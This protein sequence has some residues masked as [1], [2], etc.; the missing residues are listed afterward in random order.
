MIR[1]EKLLN[2]SLKLKLE[3]LN[4]ESKLEKYGKLHEC[5]KQESK[6]C[7]KADYRAIEQM[8]KIG[9]NEGE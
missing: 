6:Y 1:R 8:S 9:G 4:V 5:R 3:V 2:L 7:N